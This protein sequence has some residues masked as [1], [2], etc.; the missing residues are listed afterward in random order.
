MPSCASSDTIL[1]GLFHAEGHGVPSEQ[2][3]EAAAPAQDVI[4]AMSIPTTVLTE[5]MDG[6]LGNK[7]GKASSSVP[8][9]CQSVDTLKCI[10]SHRRDRAASKFLKDRVRMPKMDGKRRGILF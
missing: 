9:S 2:L 10:L 7:H 5:A 4:H 1:Q 3:T 6:L 8:K